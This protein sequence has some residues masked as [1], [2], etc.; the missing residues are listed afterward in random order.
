MKKNATARRCS[1]VAL[2]RA[3][4]IVTLAGA[5]ALGLASVALAAAPGKT[6]TTTSDTFIIPA[7]QLCD[8]TY[9]LSF[10]S[11]DTTTV[12]SDGTEVHHLV[13]FGTHTNT[14]TGYTLTER[15][16][17][18]AT[19]YPDGTSRTVG[20]FWHLRDA[21]GKLVVVQAGQLIFDDMGNLVKMTPNIDPDPAR[22]SCPALGGSPA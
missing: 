4:V 5:S 2:A 15:D 20:L 17:L 8:F 6:T 12:F 13:E 7:G 3:S 11:T 10:T 16:Q 1:Q 19:F 21:T 14:D 22:V 9:T 18:N